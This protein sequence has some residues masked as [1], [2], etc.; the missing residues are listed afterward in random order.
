M[1]SAKIRLYATCTTPIMHVICP[2]PFFLLFILGSTAVLRE[3]ENNVYAKFGAGGEGG[4][5]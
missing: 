1:M 4:G 5:K 3:I 2:Q